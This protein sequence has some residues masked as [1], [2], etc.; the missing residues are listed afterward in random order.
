[1]LLLDGDKV[2]RLR[3]FG[4]DTCLLV[5]TIEDSFGMKFT[6]DELIRAKTLGALAE[7]I[8]KKIEHPVGSQCLS[9]IAFYK[10]RRAFIEIFHTSRAKI[11]PATALY[12]LMPW[13]TRKKQ[14]RNLQDHLNYVLPPLTWPIWLV[15]FAL[16]LAGSTLYLLFDSKMS[17]AFGAAAA[18][19][20]IIAAI[21][22]LVL[23]AV[24]L[25]PLAREFPRSCGTFRDLARLVLARNYGKMAAR[26]GMSS[27][28]EVSQS[29][30]QLVAAETAADV[31]K[32]SS[33]TLFPEDLHIY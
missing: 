29:L 24:V 33:D 17:K 27:E 2:E 13:K 31:E 1:M 19:V 6:E 15:V 28:K 25:S 11:A 8:F 30:L 10:L 16:F 20:G 9:A 32:L 18:L 22:V 4:E 26:H 23:V 14:W 3:L 12:E 5:G 21:T 7:I